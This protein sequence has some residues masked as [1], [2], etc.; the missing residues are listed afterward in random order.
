MSAMPPA[1]HHRLLVLL[2][3]LLLGL[4][5]CQPGRADPASIERII[6]I[7][8][9]ITHGSGYFPG[10]VT[11]LDDVY[12]NAEIVLLGGPATAPVDG[13]DPNTGWSDWAGQVNHWVS[14]GFDADLVI[15]QGCCNRLADPGHWRGALDSL[16]AKSRGYD[17]G[18]DRRVILATTARLVPGTASYWDAYGVGDMIMETNA[19]IRETPG[20]AV[21]DIDFAW[22]VD[23]G[24]VW[25][26]PG[27]GVTRFID[28]LHLTEAG[29]RSSAEIIART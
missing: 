6:V 23:W 19:L 3:V 17:P 4:S 29:A 18:G 8:D 11:Y 15:I 9:S 5:A 14:Y 24:P 10:I 2:P 26:V 16:I 12:P 27:V 28:G 22:S 7:G 20:V 21:A 1:R 25:D 13:Y